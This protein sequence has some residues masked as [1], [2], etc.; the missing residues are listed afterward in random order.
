MAEPLESEKRMTPPAMTPE[1]LADA[2][3]VLRLSHR[4]LVRRLVPRIT[5]RNVEYWLKG[6]PV[7]LHYAE[8]IRAMLDQVTTMRPERLAAALQALGWGV[9]Y[10]AR[11][12]HV[13][14]AE[15]GMMVEGRRA[16]PLEV[17]AAVRAAF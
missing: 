12:L 8:Q 7:P 15:L 2:L 13:N 14:E 9:P 11:K 6:R 5:R 10:A 16:I 17:R 3:E 1:E 4:N